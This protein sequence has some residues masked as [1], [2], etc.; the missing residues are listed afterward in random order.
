MPVRG[1]L[2]VRGR[3][4]VDPAVTTDLEAFYREYHSPDIVFPTEY[5]AGCLLG[6]VNV[7]NVASQDEYQA[8]FP[9]GESTSPFVFICDNPQVFG[10]LTSSASALPFPHAP[11][12]FRQ[13]RVTASPAASR[14]QR[15]TCAGST[16]AC[17]PRLALSAIG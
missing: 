8:E 12:R 7:S 16:R 11:A 6:C 13:P 4:P 2:A 5:P 10:L 9:D 3:Q 17:A 14:V 1:G 15:A